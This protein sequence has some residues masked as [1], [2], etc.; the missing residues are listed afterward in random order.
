MFPSHRVL[1][2]GHVEG[3][4]V[5]CTQTDDDGSMRNVHHTLDYLTMPQIIAE[6]FST[7][8]SSDIAVSKSVILKNYLIPSVFLVLG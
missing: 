5:K 7:V 1:R 6:F 8:A 4:S 2:E 3:A